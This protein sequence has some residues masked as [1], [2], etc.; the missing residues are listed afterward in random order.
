MKRGNALKAGAE[1]LSHHLLAL[2]DIGQERAVQ[3]IHS[4]MDGIR[5][6]GSLPEPVVDSLWSLLMIVARKSVMGVKASDLMESIR[7]GL[8]PQIRE[9]I[10]REA[11]R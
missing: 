6:L 4:I 11:K 10:E 9:M 2:D 8:D 3:T 5:N 1:V 7:E